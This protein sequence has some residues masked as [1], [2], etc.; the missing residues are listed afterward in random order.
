[1]ASPNLSIAVSLPSADQVNKAAPAA[2]DKDAALRKS[3]AEFESVF[4]AEMLSH[5][6][7]DKALSE[8][9]GFGGEAFS[10]MLVESYAEEITNNGGFGLADQIYQ[11]LK[12]RSS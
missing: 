4:I 10:R 5:A 2:A 3:A 6:G 7:F 9:S 12:G 8:N 1:M 11:Q